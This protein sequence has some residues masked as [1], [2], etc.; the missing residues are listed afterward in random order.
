MHFR[1]EH[2]FEGTPAQV[3]GI[4]F[5]PSFY[6]TLELPDVGPAEIL[7]APSTDPSGARTIELRYEYTGGIDP[8]VRRL[9]G[10]A[11]LT[12]TQRLT[13]ATSDASPGSL[14]GTLAIE[15]DANASILHASANVRL[16]PA[17]E[18]GT[19]RCID[20]DLVVGLPGLG[21]IAERRIVPGV[22][23]RLEVEADALARRL[24]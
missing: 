21:G 24:A 23:R 12:W 5:D 3:A 9:L 2:H 18:G 8:V 16:E 6:A 13:L 7:E 17:L 20:G 15:G 1:A 4:L 19:R 10:G 14:T 22:L 11:A